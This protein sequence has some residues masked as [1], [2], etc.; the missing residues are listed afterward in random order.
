M[1]R[2]YLT[3]WDGGCNTCRV[4]HSMVCRVGHSM[5]CSVGHSM[6]CRVGHSMV[7]RVGHSMVCRV[8][9]SMVCIGWD[10]VWC[11]GWD[12]VW[13]VVRAELCLL[14]ASMVWWSVVRGVGQRVAC[15]ELK[16]SWCP[17][18]CTN[19]LL[20]TKQSIRNEKPRKTKEMSNMR[21]V[22]RSIKRK[23]SREYLWLQWISSWGIYLRRTNWID[24][25][26]A[27][28]SWWV[29]H[30]MSHSTIYNHKSNQSVY[31][32]L[33]DQANHCCLISH[34][35]IV[36]LWKICILMSVSVNWNE[37]TATTAWH[38]LENLWHGLTVSGSIG[39]RFTRSDMPCKLFRLS[40]F[41][42]WF[43]FEKVLRSPSFRKI[44]FSPQSLKLEWS[45]LRLI[46]N[47]LFPLISTSAERCCRSSV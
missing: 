37:L 12:T 19:E 24:S 2:H 36:H 42:I 5:V 21:R 7:C 25:V 16:C 46:I 32:V 35:A 8:G 10:T 29:L 22:V 27:V 30:A 40:L 6:V 33:T 3:G 17:L 14:A 34:L 15:K 20:E 9:H 28:M 26:G 45:I 39:F 44:Y 11:V 13:C 41:L 38:Q 1:E 23:Q 4:G 47:L 18:W 31:I 43:S